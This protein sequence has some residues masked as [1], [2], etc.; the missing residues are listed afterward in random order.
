MLLQNQYP[1]DSEETLMR[2]FAVID[3][4]GKGAIDPEK[5][6]QL[7]TTK[8][9]KFTQARASGALRRCG[10]VRGRLATACRPSALRVPALPP[11]RSS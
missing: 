3:V 9:E 11:P 2:A 5:L 4:E 8:G 10:A 7:L 6:R 1:R